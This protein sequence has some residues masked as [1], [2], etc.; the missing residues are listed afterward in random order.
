[1]TEPAVCLRR[2]FVPD[3]D[4]QSPGGPPAFKVRDCQARLVIGRP[5]LEW[6]DP[7]RD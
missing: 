5:A 4:A 2:M 7:P 6:I 3:M 1:M